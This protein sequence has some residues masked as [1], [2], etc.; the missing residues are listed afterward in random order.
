MN[1]GNRV[2]VPW[3][4]WFRALRPQFFPVMVLPVLLGA[5]VA[6]NTRGLFSF[7]SL[8]L[9]AL[10]GVLV[11]A[12]V[13]VLNDYYDH[14]N[15]ADDLN[16]TPLTP[17]AGGSRMIQNGLLTPQQTLRYGVALLA[18]A[19]LL[20]LVLTWRSGPALLLIGLVG[21]LSGYAY[22]APPL[23]LSARGLGELA[24]GL[25]FG[26]LAVLGSFFVQARG[27]DLAAFLASLPLALLVTAILYINQFPDCDTDRA[28]GKRTLVVRQGLRRA[29]TWFVVLVAGAFAALLAGIAVGELP[30][31]SALG[32]LTLPLALRAGRVLYAFYNAPHE[33]VPA[34]RATILLHAGISAALI[35]A[36]VAR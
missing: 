24:V 3:S 22:S 26:V 19:V 5:A 28:A 30:P 4:V 29:R 6:W 33:L 17:Y 36:F 32:F 20:G 1:V 7:S 18:G 23:A 34:I 11:H 16:R 10:A 12:G 35:G 21:V 27:F 31:L 15:G 8:V 2:P 9:S 14:R 13:N 25:N